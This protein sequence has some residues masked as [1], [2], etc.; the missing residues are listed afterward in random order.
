MLRGAPSLRG[1]A[2]FAAGDEGVSP[3]A[4]DGIVT[5]GQLLAVP[6]LGALA[7]LMLLVAPAV[8]SADTPSTLTVVGTSDLSDSGLEPNVI[9]PEFNKAFP[10]FTLK[11]IGSATGAAIQSAE[12]GTGGPSALIVHAPALEN[13]FVAN[14]YSYNNQ[15]GNAIF[16]NDFV[17]AGPAGDPAGVACEPRPQHRPGVRGH[18]DGR[19]TTATLRSSRAAERP[20]LPVRRSRSTQLWALLRADPGCSPSTLVL[21]DVSTADGG[22]M[23]PD[24]V[25]RSRRRLGGRAPTAAP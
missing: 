22:G 19:E 11:Y 9:L 1:L 18:R 20:P 17:L 16:T 21:C 6:I 25:R 15:Y 14:G 5:C 7:V 2:A 4:A 12:N 13:Q 8:A 3:P 24:Q 23:S 10:Q